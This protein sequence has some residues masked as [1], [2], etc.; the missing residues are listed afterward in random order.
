MIPEVR[1]FQCIYVVYDLMETDLSEVIKSEQPLEDNIIKFFLQQIL[2]AT[3]HMHDKNII[4]R[5]LVSKYIKNR[6]FNYCK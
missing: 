6:L 5:D 4:H 1:D 2:I 3:K